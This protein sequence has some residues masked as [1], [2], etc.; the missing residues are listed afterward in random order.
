MNKN[1]DY[2]TPSMLV[3]LLISTVVL[4]WFYIAECEKYNGTLPIVNNTF[5][6]LAALKSECESDL[7]RAKE[8]VMVYDFVAVDKE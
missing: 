4:A 6:N 3:I 8:C 1:L 7:T 2:G 5:E